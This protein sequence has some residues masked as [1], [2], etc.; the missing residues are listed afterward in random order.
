MSALLIW[1][2]LGVLR[3]R[4]REMLRTNAALSKET[5][6]RQWRAADL[7]LSDRSC[8][9]RGGI[10]RGQRPRIAPVAI[11]IGDF[12]GGGRAA[13]VEQQ[14]AAANGKFVGDDLRFGG[15]KRRLVCCIDGVGIASVKSVGR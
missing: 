1:L 3:R 11:E 15:K 9:V 10:V 8:L 13:D 2:F 12:L 4:Y 7:I 14:T 6:G 5:L